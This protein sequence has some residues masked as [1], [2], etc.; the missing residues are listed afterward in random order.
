LN[1]TH[2]PVHAGQARG[3]FGRNT[4]PDDTKEESGL[5]GSTYLPELIPECKANGLT[6]VLAMEKAIL[7]QER[8]KVVLVAS[9]SMTN[10][11]ILAS[12]FPKV[13]EWLKAVVIM[14]GGVQTGNIN[15][16]AEF[17]FWVSAGFL[18]AKI[19]I[20]R[21]IRKLHRSYSHFRNSR[22]N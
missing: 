20:L 3:L 16:V 1:K 9:G 21:M 18:R 13:V 2:I 22:K 4:H 14:G 15:S 5:A 19:L 8:G 7:T 17:N 6:A 10:I 11:A 12:L